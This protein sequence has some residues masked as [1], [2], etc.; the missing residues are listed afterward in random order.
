MMTSN[1]DDL[2]ELLLTEIICRLSLNKLVFQCN[3]QHDL[4]KPILS[5]LVA[6]KTGTNTGTFFPMLGM[7]S[8]SEDREEEKEEERLCSPPS[9]PSFQLPIILGAALYVVGACNDLLLCFPT[10]IHQRYYYICNPYTKQWVALP[11]TH[12]VLKSVTVGFIC[13]PYYSYSDSSSSTSSLSK[14]K[15]DND[16]CINVEYRW[17]VVRVFHNFC[18]DIFFSENGEWRESKNP[19][20]FLSELVS[21]LP[22]GVAYNGKLYWPCYNSFNSYVFEL[23]P[24][25]ISINSSSNNIIVDKC[26]LNRGPFRPS[27]FPALFACRRCLYFC[28]IQG[29]IIMFNVVE[30]TVELVP[31]I[32]GMDGYR[33][34]A[35]I[36]YPF[37]LPRWPTSIPSL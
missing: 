6:A 11:P 21:V 16:V 15:A 19:V 1:I 20:V 22:T 30:R 25:S 29:A 7:T 23:D 34:L 4:Q 26:R 3:L 12:Q 17:R 2:P 13:D 14:K 10:R 8:I 33:F 36:T 35:A 27:P 9:S 31:E 28:N 24:F 5:T 37:I 18:V 32:R